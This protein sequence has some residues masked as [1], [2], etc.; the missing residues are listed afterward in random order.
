MTIRFIF[1]SLLGLIPYLTYAGADWPLPNDER[2]RTSAQTWDK[3]KPKVEFNSSGQIAGAV[4]GNLIGYDKDG[5][6]DNNHSSSCIDTECKAD[7]DYKLDDSPDFDAPEGAQGINLKDRSG[8]LSGGVYKATQEVQLTSGDKLTVTA[9]STLYADV[10]TLDGGEIIVSSGNPDDLVIV[11][12]EDTK[13][14]NAKGVIDAHILSKKYLQINNSH[15]SGS[16]VT[17]TLNFDGGGSLGGRLPSVPQEL[18]Y[19]C[20]EEIRLDEEFTIEATY[21]FEELRSGEVIETDVDT[22]YLS[23]NHDLDKPDGGHTL[24]LWSQSRDSAIFYAP[25]VDQNDVNQ[26]K[27]LFFPRGW[28]DGDV[29]GDFYYYLNVNAQGWQLID[30]KENFDLSMDGKGSK[31]WVHEQREK[32]SLP[33]CI[34][35]AENPTDYADPAKYEFGVKECTS[36]PCTIDFDPSIEYEFT[37][38]VFVMPTIDE[39]DPDTDAPSRL[40][41]QSELNSNSTSVTIDQ[42][43]VLTDG[44]GFRR[45]EMTSISYLIIEPGIVEIDGH[46]L[47][48]G[49]VNTA[50]IGRRQNGASATNEL[51]S[52]FGLDNFDSGDPVLLHQIQSNRNLGKWMTSGRLPQPTNY[53]RNRSV[54]LFLELSGSYDDSH[55]YAEEKVA[56]LASDPSDV[57]YSNGFKMQFRNDF[58]TRR[59]SNGG[60]LANSCNEFATTDLVNI[61]GVIGNKQERSGGYGGWLRRCDI[62]ESGVSFIIDEDAT[63]RGHKP[64]KVGFFAFEES[65]LEFDSCRYFPEAVQSNRY[66][67]SGNEWVPWDGYLNISS[68]DNEGNRLNLE[69]LTKDQALAFSSSIVSGDDKN[70]CYYSDGQNSNGRCLVDATRN[71]FP[72]GPPNENAFEPQGD[73]IEVDR[74]EYTLDSPLRPGN[75]RSISFD[76]DKTTLVLA[77]GEYWI[78]EL[79]FNNKEVSIAVKNTTIIHY[80]SIKF[81]QKHKLYLNAGKWD[82]SEDESG[83]NPADLTLIGHG[84][85]SYFY[86]EKTHDLR[87]IGNL[88]VSPSAASVG[89][90]TGSAHR[91]EM[92]GALTAPIINFNAHKDSYINAQPLENC[93]TNPSPQIDKITIKPFNFHLI[94][95]VSEVQVILEGEGELSGYT[96]EL[97][98]PTGL[99]LLE[100]TPSDSEGKAIY[101]VSNTTQNVGDY[102]LNAILALGSS[103]LQ[104]DPQD[105]VYV[106]YKI[107]FKNNGVDWVEPGEEGYSDQSVVSFTAGREARIDARVLGCNSGGSEVLNY[108]KTLTNDD[109]SILVHPEGGAGDFSLTDLVFGSGMTDEESPS[110]VRFNN[111]GEVVVK[112]T[113]EDFDCSTAVEDDCPIDGSTLQG[114]FTLKVR[115][116]KIAICEVKSEHKSKVFTNRGTTDSGLGFMPAG[117]E[118]NITYRPIVY[119]DFVTGGGKCAYP[120]AT[121][122]AKDNGPLSVSTSVVYPLVHDPDALP[123]IE[124]GNFSSSDIDVKVTTQSFWD[125]VGSFDLETSA[126]YLSMA[127]DTDTETIGRFYPD[128][129]TVVSNS[130]NDPDNQSFTYMNQ[131]FGSVEA[132]VAAY[133]FLDNETTNYGEFAAD[134]Q[135]VFSLDDDDE[136][137][138]NAD[139]GSLSTVSSYTGSRWQLSS[140]EISWSKRTDF[141]ADGPFNVNS[142]DFDGSTER[143]TF[144]E[145]SPS[146]AGDP[147]QFKS[148]AND[149]DDVVREELPGDHPRVVYGRVNLSDAGGVSGSRITVPLQVEYWNGVTFVRNDADSFT[150]I[151]AEEA[152]AEVIWPAGATTT[153][154][155]SGEAD[156]IRGVSNEFIAEQTTE[157][158][159][160]VEIWQELDSTDNPMPWLMFDWDQNQTDEENPST[161]VTFGIHRGNDRVIYRGEPGL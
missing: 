64:E 9:P 143:L 55:N 138:V 38:L 82:G 41:I 128:Y 118:F 40:Y 43:S 103:S 71:L 152:D 125:E 86:P 149:P 12:K 57:L 155:L 137:I 133:S 146:L 44:N 123:N 87:F 131:E 48:A 88:Y 159:E 136:R 121:N 36:M 140:S 66:Y 22:L 97:I 34:Q 95:D 84:S 127:L 130:W 134:L 151:E 132:E 62:E 49:F 50:E 158:R 27:I 13:F 124:E 1:L 112:V 78:G 11:T 142:S 81:N 6:F 14:I 24:E 109:V 93:G 102:T 75:Y 73:D 99:T 117:A 10:F 94:C 153:A 15:V 98:L 70:G 135:A 79:N 80:N 8:T 37:P 141:V 25:E 3:Q 42:H 105:M 120:I 32:W 114:A 28:R 161:V 104:A 61:D 21:H 111:S 59:Q 5:D 90:N 77:G 91:F 68:S 29:I 157:T 156:I 65:Q 18:P 74:D 60:S 148:D 106:P 89:F 154:T 17:N 129:F 115:P 116:W 47:V 67:Q 147:V 119:A 51:F 54:D 20:E 53:Q 45:K 26:I 63:E 76:D 69:H 122:Y 100:S 96:P 58:T 56:F 107:D 33:S 110:S 4:N 39:N 7:K 144:I 150:D 160:Q 108:N 2:P 19:M 101:K 31:G 139:A 35:D 30:T 23:H 145:I 126:T 72:D 92:T 83:F 85:A 113:D 16:I 46:K 52:N